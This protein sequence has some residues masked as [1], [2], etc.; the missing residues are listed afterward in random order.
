MLLG[1]YCRRASS[2]SRDGCLLLAE[3]AVCTLCYNTAGG[4]EHVPA[5]RHGLSHG[6]QVRIHSTHPYLVQGR[7]GDANEEGAAWTR[8]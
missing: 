3:Y 1:R 6:R 2:R 8:T 5:A 4:R 7:P